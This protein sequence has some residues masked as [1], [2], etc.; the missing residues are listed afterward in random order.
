[1]SRVT[2][3][4]GSEAATISRPPV[5]PLC[6]SF[7][8]LRLSFVCDVGLLCPWGEGGGTRAEGTEP[9]VEGADGLQAGRAQGSGRPT[10][11]R[12]SS[13]EESPLGPGHPHC[14]PGHSIYRL[15]S[16]GEGQSHVKAFSSAESI[17]EMIVGHSGMRA[18]YCTVIPADWMQC[19]GSWWS[20][21]LTSLVGSPGDGS[22]WPGAHLLGCRE[23]GGKRIN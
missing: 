8:G 12:A 2:R 14:S 21:A 7:L 13:R 22:Q 18:A 17:S 10:L 3:R 1:M 4:E 15:D 6:L 20:D 11:P 9:L 16:E 19:C 5:L 23:V